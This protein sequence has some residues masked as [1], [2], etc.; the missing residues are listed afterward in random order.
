LLKSGQ[1]L[2]PVMMAFLSRLSGISTAPAVVTSI[3]S[4]APIKSIVSVAFPSS[5]DF[6]YPLFLLISKHEKKPTDGS[7]Q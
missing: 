1:Q 4:A 5:Q 6:H 7:G 2:Q 3:A